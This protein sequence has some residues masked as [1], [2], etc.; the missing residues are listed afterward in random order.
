MTYLDFVNPETLGSAV[1]PYKKPGIH[2]VQQ[3]R[4][5]L[6]GCV[7]EAVRS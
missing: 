5:L 2:H 6:V 1:L 7:H 4:R 3:L